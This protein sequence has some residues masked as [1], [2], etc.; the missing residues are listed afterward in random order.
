MG[1]IFQ[2]A[3]PPDSTGSGTAVKYTLYWVPPLHQRFQMRKNVHQAWVISPKPQKLFRNFPES[4]Q[5]GRNTGEE[6]EFVTL[7]A[8]CP[9]GITLSPGREK[10]GKSHKCLPV[11]PIARRA[12]DRKGL[13]H[14]QAQGPYHCGLLTGWNSSAG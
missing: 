14:Y 5:Q 6:K 9:G 3:D 4:E 12:E 10:A 11:I 7:P 13:I 2:R 8:T 1:E